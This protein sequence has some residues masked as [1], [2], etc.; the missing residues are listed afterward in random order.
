MFKIGVFGNK[1]LNGAT[2]ISLIMM[3]LVLF[4]PVRIA[5]SL[6]ILP[7]KY[8]LYALGLILVPVALM[9]FAKFT[10]LVKNK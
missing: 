4:T 10:G 2:L 8:Y 3:A 9:E 5:F 1:K 6:V 7:A